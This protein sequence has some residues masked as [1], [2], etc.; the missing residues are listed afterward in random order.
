MI[1]NWNGRSL[2]ATCLEAVAASLWPHADVLVTDNGSTDGSAE[3]VERDYPWASLLRLPTNLGAAGGRNAAIAW[4]RRHPRCDWMFFIDNDTQLEPDTIAQLV[5]VAAED[6]RIGIV[7]AKAFREKGD[8]VLLAAGGMG[9][10]PYT[11]GTWDVAAGEQ[12]RGQHDRQRDVQ[13]CPGYAMFVRAAVIERAGGFDDG[14]NPYGWEDVDFSLRAGRAG[15]RIVYAPRAV[16]YH[17]GGRI[18]RGAVAVYEAS[19][20]KHLV[21]LVR[22]N[23]NRLQWSCFLVLFPLRSLWRVLRELVVGDPRIVGV[24]LKGLLG[25][26]RASGGPG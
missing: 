13:A 14:F 18:G 4:A 11:G 2:L 21:R 5:A 3:L 17:A 23:S 9:F 26:R 24:W 19:K 10:N 20:A 1:L 22:R 6:E 16:V 15:F 7:T 12:D 25:R 8:R